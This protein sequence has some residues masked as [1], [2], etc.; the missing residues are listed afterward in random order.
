MFAGGFVTCADVFGD[1]PLA[2]EGRHGRLGNDGVAH[3]ASITW[4]C[5]CPQSWYHRSSVPGLFDRWGPG[6]CGEVTGVGVSRCVG[7]GAGP[8]RPTRAEALGRAVRHDV[9]R[10]PACRG[11]GHVVSVFAHRARLMLG[12]LAATEE[13]NE[14]LP[15]PLAPRTP[16]KAGPVAGHHGRDARPDRHRHADPR[17]NEVSPPDDRH[18]QPGRAA[19]PDHRP[20][21]GAGARDRRLPRPRPCRDPQPRE[22]PPP[23]GESVSRTPHRSRGS[24]AGA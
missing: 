1:T 16:A 6:A 11:R 19:R 15:R 5:P 9:A 17:H 23:R 18:V 2:S 24:P 10:L 4:S 20:A 3:T 14:V 13:G 21:P 7:L 8:E 12:Q 22:H